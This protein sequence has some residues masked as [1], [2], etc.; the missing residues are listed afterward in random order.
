MNNRKIT[1]SLRLLPI[2]LK[3][4]D[5]IASNSSEAIESFISDFPLLLKGKK[6]HGQRKRNTFFE[7]RTF[8]FSSSLRDKLKKTGNMS[9][10]VD[11]V[12]SAIL[13]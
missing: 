12:L 8:T 13:K 2:N 11:D 4:L 7:K 6:Y 1:I 3:R 5:A 9:Q 10:A